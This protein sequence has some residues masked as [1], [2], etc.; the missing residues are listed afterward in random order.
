[1]AAWRVRTMS[2]R[3]NAITLPF[4][5]CGYSKDTGSRSP[6]PLG[7]PWMWIWMSMRRGS[8]AARRGRN[9]TT[10]AFAL[11][12]LGVGE[13]EQHAGVAWQG[14]APAHEV[15]ATQLGQRRH[16]L[17]LLDDPRPVFCDDLIARA[18]ASVLERICP[19][20]FAKSNPR[21]GP[22][23]VDGAGRYHTAA[24]THVQTAVVMRCSLPLMT[25]EAPAVIS[26]QLGSRPDREECGRRPFL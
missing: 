19:F 12:T 23:D 13:F 9:A 15:H 25:R 21:H 1:M 11:E 22:A 14:C 18:V 4:G 17:G 20:A 6:G 8:R 26:L 2:R 7:K 5:S 3:G 16:Q 10:F 24:A